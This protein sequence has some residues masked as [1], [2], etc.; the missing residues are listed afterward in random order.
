MRHIGSIV[1]SII[2]APVIFIL[3]GVGMVK[4][5]SNSGAVLAGQSTDWTAVGIG[6]GAL[7]VAGGL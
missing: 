3:T 1:L 5:G 6:A 4:F 2:F 7:I